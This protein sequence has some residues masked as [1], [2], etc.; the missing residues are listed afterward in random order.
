VIQE[1]TLHDGAQTADEVAAWLV[2]WLGETRRSLDIALYDVRL[3]GPPGD[4]VADA[5]RA[6]AGRG[7]AVRIAFNADGNRARKPLPPPPRTER[8]LLE[9][10]GVP[11]RAIPGEPDLMHHKY[12]VRDLAAVW[13]GSTNWTLDS[14]TREENV[15]VTV[16]S[17]ALAHAYA[18]DFEDLWRRGRV[19]GSG[20]FDVAP[21]DVG[22]TP[23]RAWF[24]PGR[25]PELSA[26]I[27]KRILAAKRRVRIASPVL[28]AAPILA[29]LNQAL[30]EAR[31]DVAGVGDATQI[32]QV[33]AQW[34]DNE[35]S[36][37][38]GPLLARVLNGL[39]WSGKVS[40]PY[41]PGA[42]H[43]YMHAKVTVADDVVFIGSFNLSRSGE[44]N[45]ENVLEI[46]DAGLAQRMASF[47]DVVRARYPAVAVP[48]YA[49]S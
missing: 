9:A 21:V 36:A 25:G 30:S 5:I 28:T 22:G 38:K 49:A 43:D 20:A 12:V 31:V 45:A 11:L 2:E 4:L 40:T 24:S 13:T 17:E 15:L 47:I 3:P 14:W 26:R 29:A 41:A 27:A 42:V 8:S 39:P 10:L 23:V 46:V 32:G 48:A 19:E 34:R 16:V 37:W 44:E 1:R 6:A 35:H 7:V 33:F 18:R